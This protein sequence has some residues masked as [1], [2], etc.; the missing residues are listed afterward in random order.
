MDAIEERPLSKVSD[1]NTP[2]MAVK[3]PIPL[4]GKHLLVVLSSLYA[5]I[6]N[7]N[8]VFILALTFK[9]LFAEQWTPTYGNDYFLQPIK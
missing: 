4:A 7:G 8:A 3:C 1:T 9:P 6:A 5:L 2:R